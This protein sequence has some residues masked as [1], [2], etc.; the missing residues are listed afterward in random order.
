M[1]RRLQLA[2]EHHDG[3]IEGIG[4]HNEA[5]LSFRWRSQGLGLRAGLA[6]VAVAILFDRVSRGALQNTPSPLRN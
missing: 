4:A 6:I 5:P 2:V 3:F 1:R